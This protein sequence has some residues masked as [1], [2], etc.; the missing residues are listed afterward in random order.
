MYANGDGVPR[1]QAS[2]L[3]WFK[4]AAEA[5]NS[6]GMLDIGSYY[7]NQGPNDPNSYK[8][9]MGGNERKPLVPGTRRRC[10]PASAMSEESEWYVTVL[11]PR[12]V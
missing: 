7:V 2:E 4:K 11:V 9:G 6:D 5:G 12:M 1:D 8:V 3:A 10:T